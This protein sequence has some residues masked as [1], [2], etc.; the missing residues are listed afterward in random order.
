VGTVTKDKNEIRCKMYCLFTNN[1]TKC[2]GIKEEN[3]GYVS[4]PA[5]SI[6]AEYN[7]RIIN[8]LSWKGPYRS[9]SSNPPAKSRDTFQ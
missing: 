9:S 6:T 4:A 5:I 2:E 1:G 8:G 3:S 7:H